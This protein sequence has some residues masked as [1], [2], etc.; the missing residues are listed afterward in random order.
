MAITAVSKGPSC[1]KCGAEMVLTGMEAICAP[2]A[3]M[4]MLKTY[5]CPPCKEKPARATTIPVRK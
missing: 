1:E 4:M 3:P 5:E 2:P